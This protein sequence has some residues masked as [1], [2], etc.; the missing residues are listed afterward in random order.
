MNQ[1]NRG[2]AC[3]SFAYKLCSNYTTVLIYWL[4]AA[5]EYC[6]AVKNCITACISELAGFFNYKSF[7]QDTENQ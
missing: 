7:C 2:L 3:N 4:Q 6:L 5:A 1:P